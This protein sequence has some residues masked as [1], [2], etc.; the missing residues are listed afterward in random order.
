M[1]VRFLPRVALSAGV[2]IE[3]DSYFTELH[4]TWKELEQ[5]MSLSSK[6]V[7]NLLYGCH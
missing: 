1:A 6:F 5:F 3:R 7:F 2:F 4:H